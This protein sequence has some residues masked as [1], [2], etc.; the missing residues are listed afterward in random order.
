MRMFHPRLLWIIAA[1]QNLTF[2]TAAL[3]QKKC[4]RLRLRHCLLQRRATF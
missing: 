3:I 4:S 2:Q 1:S